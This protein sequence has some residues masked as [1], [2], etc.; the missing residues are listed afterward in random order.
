[1]K[2]KSLLALVTLVVLFSM[3]LAGCGPTEEPTE[4]VTEEP[5]AAFEPMVVRW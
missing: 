4:V 5:V 3:V 2:H 1:V